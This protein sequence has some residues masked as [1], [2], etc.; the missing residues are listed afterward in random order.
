MHFSKRKFLALVLSIAPALACAQSTTDQQQQPDQSQ[1]QAPTTQP[2]QQRAEVLRAAQARVRARRKL[3][4]Q[5][6][7]QDT[8]SHK[9]ETYFG[10]GYLRFRPGSSLQKINE[11]NW[12]IGVTDYVRG[13][14][15]V[16][17]DFRG[18]YGTT[19]T[20]VNEFQVFA[21][22]ISQYSFMAGPQARFYESQHWA[23]SGNVLV[24]VGHGNFGTGTGGL[25]PTLIGLYPDGNSVNL[26]VGASLDYNLGPGLAIRLTPNY[27]MTDYGS[28]LQHNLG[29]NAG[30]VYRFGRQ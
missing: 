6:I 19:Y 11:S 16:T 4:V 25:P 5:Q 8:Y 2:P 18:Y 3:R 21:P 13:K 22:S 30:I 7:I 17:A 12:N 28:E 15:G 26:S 20:N 14:L 24:G 1:T 29:F 27:L 10:G 9:Y 23:W